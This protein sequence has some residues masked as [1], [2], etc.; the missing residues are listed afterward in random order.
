M[1]VAGC[2]KEVYVTAMVHVLSS[3]CTRCLQHICYRYVENWL[4]IITPYVAHYTIMLTYVWGMG[5]RL[6]TARVSEGDGPEGI[7]LAQGRHAHRR[8][9]PNDHTPKRKLRDTILIGAR[10]TCLAYQRKGRSSSR[11]TIGP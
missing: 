5:T 8:A 1:Y 6:L 3:I 4:C 7:F 9:M 2:N 11:E 10:K